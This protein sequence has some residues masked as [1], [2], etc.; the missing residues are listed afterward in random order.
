MASRFALT[1]V[2]PVARASA[3]NWLVWLILANK[4]TGIFA[5]AEHLQAAVA[6]TANLEGSIED[7]FVLPGKRLSNS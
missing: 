3:L 1:Q 2:A 5:R 6:E 4:W 7:N